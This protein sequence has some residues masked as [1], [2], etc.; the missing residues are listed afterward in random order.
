MAAKT[1]LFYSSSEGNIVEYLTLRG[2]C[3]D[4]PELCKEGDDFDF[5]KKSLAGNG[6]FV[7][8]NMKIAGDEMLDVGFASVSSNDYAFIFFGE[9]DYLNVLDVKD[10]NIRRFL[11]DLMHKENQFFIKDLRRYIQGTLSARELVLYNDKL[12]DINERNP[13][14]ESVL[15]FD[16]NWDLLEEYEAL[17]EGDAWVISDVFSDRD[18]DLEDSDYAKDMW[19]DGYFKDNFHGKSKELY[20]ELVKKMNPEFDLNNS[21]DRDYSHVN[22]KIWRHF[23]D[24]L[25]DIFYVYTDL[26]NHEYKLA[27]RDAII[28]ESNE[29]FPQYGI[30]V[31]WEGDYFSISAGN[32]YSLMRTE[33]LYKATGTEATSKILAE[34]MQSG[35]FSGWNEN[36]YEFHNEKYFDYDHMGDVAERQFT[37]MIE[38]WDEDQEVRNEM[39]NIFKQ[40]NLDFYRHNHETIGDVNIKLER[41]DDTP[42]FIKFWV[43]KKDGGYRS[44]YVSVHISDL[45]KFLDNPKD[46]F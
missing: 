31:N 17:E 14:T 29:L 26:K 41:I 7:I 30:N 23:R 2:I 42:G 33:N 24:E 15:F 40:Y 34:I 18:Y 43:Q 5:I 10:Y 13:R 11:Q 37:K 25:L 35:G 21:K 8:K 22:D 12:D 4:Y 27:T 38:K 1:K 46:F 45:R 39:E 28:K 16:I 44:T 20:E 6:F 3:E 19:S 9:R 36:R 32:L